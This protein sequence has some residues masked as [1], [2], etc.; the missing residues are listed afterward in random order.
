M[1]GDSSHKSTLDELYELA[2]PTSGYFTRAQ[3]PNRL[4]YALQYHERQGRLEKVERG[5][6]RLVHA[7]PTEDEQ[8]IVAYLWSS[9]LGVISEESA[10]SIHE[11]SDVLP[12][13]TVLTLEGETSLTPP[14]GVRLVRRAT[15]YPSD[16]VTWYGPVRVTTPWQTLL[17][18]ALRGM[19]PRT[20][21]QAVEQAMSRRLVAQDA[22]KRL[23]LAV[24]D[25]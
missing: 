23:M 18:L 14:Q 25:K 24:V 12:S 10:L 2:A 9:G 6:Y 7:A 4:K 13:T 1:M 8:Y 22:W 15:R 21:E 17:D 20:F 16:G 19:E 5:I 3:L 11:L